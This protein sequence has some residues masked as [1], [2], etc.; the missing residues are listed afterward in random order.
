MARK[1]K[2]LERQSAASIPNYGET[3]HEQYAAQHD[4]YT[5]PN[6]KPLVRP[7]VPRTEHR[8]RYAH[9][10]EQAY[11][12]P[13]ISVRAVAEMLEPSS[14]EVQSQIAAALGEVYGATHLSPLQ[15][16]REMQ[17][18][19]V[20]RDMESRGA[21]SKVQAVLAKW[22][23]AMRSSAELTKNDRSV[24]G[25]LS[26]D[27]INRNTQHYDTALRIRGLVEEHAPRGRYAEYGAR[28]EEE[29]DALQKQFG[30]NANYLLT[31]GQKRNHDALR[32]A[33]LFSATDENYEPASTMSQVGRYVGGFFGPII[34]AGRSVTTEPG[35]YDPRR[36]GEAWDDAA[37]I[38]KPQGKYGYAANRWQAGQQP[39]SE[40]TS[41]FNAE[42]QSKFNAYDPTTMRGL[43]N[44]SQ[45][46]TSFPYARAY[47]ALAPVRELPM[48]IGLALGGKDAGAIDGL[49]NLR[50]RSNS[51]VPVVP[52]GMSEPEFRNVTD[53]LRD[54]D[55]KMDGWTS[56]YFGPKFADAVNTAT[57]QV[58]GKMPRTYLSPFAN[59]LLSVP[60]ESLGDPAN[61]VM[62][63][64]TGPVAGAA[65]GGLR[66]GA[67]GMAKG[68]L[69]GLVTGA[70]RMKGD[71]I[72][73]TAE[74]A[75]VMG[76]MMSGI[77]EFLSPEK[78]NLMMGDKN[79]ND[80]DYDQQLERKTQGAMDARLGAMD[81]WN[82]S[83][84]RLAPPQEPIG[85]RPMWFGTQ[86]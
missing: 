46:N 65:F 15:V 52:K 31:P 41:V 23:D 80:K 42:G 71:A 18:F 12:S 44:A 53:Q 54:A 70:V 72:E 3:Q 73:E 2:G 10:V 60:G 76:P 6:R 78:D 38:A 30:D 58:F 49:R 48:H 19:S 81:A 86:R 85:Q 39:D 84:K 61:L 43:A 5:D 16:A 50:M 75:A 14:P 51:I 28:T 55:T 33:E 7:P 66:G 20:H 83:Q 25:V 29:Q 67:A 13:V 32:V 56:A 45:M 37:L 77:G 26:G 63:V 62:N 64:A 57:G 8:E 22:T 27:D 59:A 9:A 1:G 47:T 74:E 40:Y 69:K 11:R 34:D 35:V 17:V 36:T 4:A 68:A 24:L 79:P 82:R 21:D